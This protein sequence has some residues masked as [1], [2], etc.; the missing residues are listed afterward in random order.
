LGRNV[1]KRVN[2]GRLVSGAKSVICLGANYFFPAPAKRSDDLCGVVARYARGVDYHEVV[3]QK[4]EE[5]AGRIEEFVDGAGRFRCFV[6]TAPV[7][8]KALAARAGL[9]WIGKNGLLLNRRFGSWLVLGEIV[10]DLVLDYD[11]P[12]EDGCGDCQRCMEAC[13][14]GALAAERI[15]EPRRCI[16]YLTIESKAEITEELG[17]K[18]GGR[19]FG[20]DACQEACPYCRRAG[21]TQ[22]AEFEP[23]EEWT[24]LSLDEIA[25][26]KQGEFQRKFRGSSLLRVELKHLQQVAAWCRLNED[27]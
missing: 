8:E 24:Y 12:V 10:T 7:A 4:L 27:S 9:G 25:E 3:K 20:C 18:L 17:E 22:I 21:A 14:T 6:D 5:L 23:R 16:S 13:P 26:M 19:I 11:K 15:L 2:V 1:D